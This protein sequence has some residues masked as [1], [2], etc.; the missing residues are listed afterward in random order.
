[1]GAAIFFGSYLFTLL[2]INGVRKRAKDVLPNTS[3]L[4]YAVLAGTLGF[5]VSAV[6]GS[7]AHVSFLVLQVIF[8]WTLAEVVNREL[9]EIKKGRLLVAPA[10]PIV[11][12]QRRFH[13]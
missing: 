7:M 9:D 4:L 1:V 2:W 12:K 10:E 6:F 11:P 13:R 5:F 3:R 8:L